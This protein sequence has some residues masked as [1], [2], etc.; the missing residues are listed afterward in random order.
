MTWVRFHEELTR[1]A[2]AD[3]TRA[4]RFVYLEL[5]LE[6]QKRTVMVGDDAIIEISAKGTPAKAIAAL[7]GGEAMDIVHAMKALAAGDDPMVSVDE[8]PDGRR[9]LVIRKWA[10]WNRPSA[11]KT[12]TAQ[13]RLAVGGRQVARRLAVG[14]RQVGGSSPVAGSEDQ[15]SQEVGDHKNSLEQNRTE[16]NR[17][18]EDPRAD[19]ARPARPKAD[20]AEP[21]PKAHERYADAYAAGMRDASDQPFPEPRAK[22]DLV[23][24]ATTYGHDASGPLTGDNLL[25]WFRRIAAEYRRA[26]ADSAIYE[27]GYAPSHCLKWLAAGRPG[28]A[29]QSFQDASPGLFGDLGQVTIHRPP[30]PRQPPPGLGSAQ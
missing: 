1:G 8:R 9:F 28:N 10:F 27:S 2:K 5:C 24:M 6:A 17:T 3:L 4:T 11:G 29:P 30:K 22:S 16:E 12:V 20:S 26:K 19:A 15:Q 21:K 14:G 18:E 7:L 25:A 23:Q 13:A